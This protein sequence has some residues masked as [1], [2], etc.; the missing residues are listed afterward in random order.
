V[1]ANP[2]ESVSAGTDP[3]RWHFASWTN[4]IQEGQTPCREITK[5]PQTGEKRWR[6]RLGDISRFEPTKSGVD[7]NYGKK[8]A[9]VLGWRASPV[10][11]G[12][13]HDSFL[14][15]ILLFGPSVRGFVGAGD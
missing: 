7:K 13:W 11:R 4:R 6:A 2:T 12:E 15:A 5:Y 8:S 3:V 10:I 1:I 14:F 9:D